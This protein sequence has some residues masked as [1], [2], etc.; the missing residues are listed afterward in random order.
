MKTYR[1]FLVGIALSQLFGCA[2]YSSETKTDPSPASNTKN[3]QTQQVDKRVQEQVL[4]PSARI[5][6]E[7]KPAQEPVPAPPPPP[8]P[9][10]TF[11]TLEAGDNFATDSSKLSQKGIDLLNNAISQLVAAKIISI[12]VVGHTDS[13][14][15]EAYNQALGLRR[16]NAV[17]S[18]LISKGVDSSIIK[19][20]SR[21]ELEPVS[22][23]KT[24]KGR[25]ENRRVKI[26]FTSS[27]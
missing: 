15:S 6:K 13:V 27:N 10:I 26:K 19:I 3:Q 12:E 25:A 9:K 5:V 14:G 7:V 2:Y 8:E 17:S 22:S 24:E 20:D 1:Y 11:F 21:G 4:L 16:A 18:Y 23:N